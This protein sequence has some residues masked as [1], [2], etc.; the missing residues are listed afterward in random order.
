MVVELALILAEGLTRVD[1]QYVAFTTSNAHRPVPTLTAGANGC[2]R[3]KFP[4]RFW[5]NKRPFFPRKR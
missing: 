3:S 1:E 5:S 2:C 4:Y